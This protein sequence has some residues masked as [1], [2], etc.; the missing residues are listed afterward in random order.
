MILAFL[1]I[2]SIF[3]TLVFGTDYVTWQN[4][5]G[6]PIFLA[7]DRYPAL[8]TGDFGDCLGGQSLIN[9][10]QF[11]AAYYQDNMTVLF[12]IAGTTNLRNES[13]MSMSITLISWV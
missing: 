3:P 10:T 5:A 12:H 1:A 4:S 8:Y 2:F 7:N 13:I 11:D 6:Q 9:V